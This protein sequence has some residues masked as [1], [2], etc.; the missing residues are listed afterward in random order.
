VFDFTHSVVKMDP[1]LHRL[2]AQRSG[3]TDK[4]DLSL[5]MLKGALT[6]CPSRPVPRAL[7]GRTADPAVAQPVEASAPVRRKGALPAG[8]YVRC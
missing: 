6:F 3:V 7:F 2:F 8:T 5:D 1:A 4:A